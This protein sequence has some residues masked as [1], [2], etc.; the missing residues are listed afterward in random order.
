MT[1]IAQARF[2]YFTARLDEHIKVLASV[3]ILLR[4]SNRQTKKGGGGTEYYTEV[5]N[6]WNSS[7]WPQAIIESHLARHSCCN[8]PKG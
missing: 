2:T 6:V 5:S 8:L 1:D 7:T 3:F 4:K